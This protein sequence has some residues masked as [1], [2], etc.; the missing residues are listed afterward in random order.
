VDIRLVGVPA[1]DGMKLPGVAFEL[2]QVVDDVDAEA[3]DLECAGAGVGVPGAPV[4]VPRTAATGA[5]SE[6]RA[7]RA[8]QV[9]REG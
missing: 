9:P 1:H 2:L 3:S 8:A 4:V 5:S 7:P 6:P